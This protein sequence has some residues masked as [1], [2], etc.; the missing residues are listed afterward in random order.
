M[1]GSY[2]FHLCQCVILSMMH[3]LASWYCY[4]FALVVIIIG[5]FKVGGKKGEIFPLCSNSLLFLFHGIVFGRTTWAW[6][7]FLFSYIFQYN[8]Y[9]LRGQIVS[10][11]INLGG[12]MCM[13]NVELT[14]NI[15]VLCEVDLDI[16]DR[17]FGWVRQTM[18]LSHLILRLFELF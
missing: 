9:L 11:S 18:P 5:V 13:E 1:L 2:L 16:W 8:Y 7:W 14:D 17:V 12:G 10:G 3:L 4:S 15:Y 6:N